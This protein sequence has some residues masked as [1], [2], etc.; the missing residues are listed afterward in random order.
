VRTLP[1]VAIAILALPAVSGACS[2]PPDEKV[3]VVP[4]WGPSS[5]GPAPSSGSSSGSGAGSS[6]GSSGAPPFASQTGPSTHNAGRDCLQCHGRGG[7]D[8]PQF[9]FGGTLYDGNGNAVVGAEVR[10]VDANGNGTSVYTGPSGTFY[11]QGAGFAAPANVGVRNATNT[12][13]MLVTLQSS[14][15]G[16]SSCHCTG[17]GCS[18]TPIHLP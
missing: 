3:V 7:G 18:T 12:A 17:T 10:L 8:A 1:R 9:T 14:G 2:S 16:C 4:G 13:E 11:S 6:G 5:P 15:G